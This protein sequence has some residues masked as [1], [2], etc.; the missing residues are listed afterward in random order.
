MAEP[1]ST[2]DGYSASLA[3]VLQS[4][5][6]PYGITLTVWASGASIDHF[7]GPPKI[8]EIFLFVLGAVAAY[9][10]LALA[11]AQ[12]L[13]KAS[14]GPAGQRMAVTGTLHVVSI[15][16]AL[17]AVT[18]IGEIQSWAAWPLG[19]FA[20]IGLY[21]AVVGLEYAW[22]PGLLRITKD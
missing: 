4:A 14:R 20:G 19:G 6:V 15:G 1:G 3:T 5:A 17:G 12:A 11:V 21:L 22:A 10:A 9:A 13:R 8:Y 7:R 18:L 2:G 16:V